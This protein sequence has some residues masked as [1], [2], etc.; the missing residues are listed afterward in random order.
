MSEFINI[1]LFLLALINP[2]SKIAV[3]S[4]L[5]ETA[6]FREIRAIAIRSTIAAFL[7][8]VAFAV[9]GNFILK[10]VFR[11]ELYAFQIVGGF[12]AFFYGFMALRQGVFFEVDANQSVL[13][14]SI[15]PIASPLIAGPATITGVISLSAQSS[16]LV[17]LPALAAALFVNL[18]FMLVTRFIAKTLH[19]FNVLGALIRI[20]G[21]FVASIGVN[22]ILTGLRSY[23]ATIH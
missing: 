9:A 17:V 13:D 15:V 20:I 21:L 2:V 16:I 7:M 3:I 19:R 14:L 6:S 22:M 1:S 8:L 23:I 4:A 12:V 10:D 5:S 18:A 11:V